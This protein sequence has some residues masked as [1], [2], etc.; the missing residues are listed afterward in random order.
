MGWLAD[1][2]RVLWQKTGGIAVMAN[3]PFL[4]ASDALS[5]SGAR[6]SELAR[7]FLRFLPISGA[8]ISTFGSF[9][10]AE[11]ISATDARA[12]R[13]DE[14]QFDLGEGPCWDALVN[15]EPVLEPDL[16][17]TTS[18]SWPTFLDAIREEEIGAIFAFPL[19]FGPLE[20]GAVDLYSIAP[21]SL[22]PEQQGQTLALSALV[23]RIILRHA[24]STDSIPDDTTT[25]SR[26]LIHQATGMVLAQLGTTAEDAHLIIQARAFAENRPMRQ[27]A[28]DVIERRIRFTALT[29]T[30]RSH[31]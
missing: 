23:S 21:V 22:T 10:G 15:R 2:C 20:I 27:I 7:P 31:E 14:L 29:N 19:L 4:M 24:I 5:D 30:G 26:R 25:F 12:G 3:D 13:V 9:L 8:S 18:V 1:L 16:A 11:T 28:Q 17:S 6:I